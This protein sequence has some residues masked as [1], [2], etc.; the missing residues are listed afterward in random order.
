MPFKNSDRKKD[1]NKIRNTRVRAAVKAKALEDQRMI[2]EFDRTL[3]QILT[4]IEIGFNARGITSISDE[5][6]EETERSL[7]KSLSRDLQNF[8]KEN[9]DEIAQKLPKIYKYVLFQFVIQTSH[10]NF[11][12]ANS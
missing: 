9:S 6:R 10:S 8:M 7:M 11:Y 1:Y 3:N 4:F 5:V 12:T 2:Q